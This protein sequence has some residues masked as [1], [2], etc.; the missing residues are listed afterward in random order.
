[1]HIDDDS[2]SNDELAECGVEDNELDS[3]SGL[4]LP[5]ALPLTHRDSSLPREALFIGESYAAPALRA[6]FQRVPIAPLAG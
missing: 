6:C 3:P 2:T 1:V 4:H 5:A